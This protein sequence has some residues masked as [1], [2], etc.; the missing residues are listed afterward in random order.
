MNIHSHPS[1]TKSVTTYFESL[2]SATSGGIPTVFVVVCI[3]FLSMVVMARQLGEP[4]YFSVNTIDT[5]TY[6]SWAW[7]FN[8][9]LKEGIIYPR[10]LSLNFWGYGSPTFV[11]YPPLAFYLV[12]LLSSLTDSLLFAMSLAKFTS[13]FF[14]GVAMFYLIREFYPVRIALLAASLCIIFPY[15]VVQ[16]YLMGTFSSS[17]SFMWFPAIMLFT[18]RFIRTGEYRQLLYA[19]VC[20]GG[21][22]LTHLINAYMFSFVIL[23]F[24]VLTSI[25]RKTPRYLI[26]IPLILLTGF[27]IGA[28]YLLPLVFE[29]RYFNLA[30]FIGKGYRYDE[31]FLLPHQ[32]VNV[33]WRVYYGIF[34]SQTLFLFMMLLTIYF[35]VKFA[36]PA[37]EQD[38]LMF[39]RCSQ[40][41]VLTS[42]F[43]LFG[44]STSI[45][46]SIPFIKYVQFP[47]RW[48]N[49]TTF[50]ILALSASGFTALAKSCNSKRKFT[51]ILLGLFAALSVWDYYYIRHAPLYT[52]E[53]LLPAKAVNWAFEHLPTGVAADKIENENPVGREFA[54]IQGGGVAKVLRWGSGERIVR[55]A[56]RKASVVKIRTFNFPGW[57]ARIDGR[58]AAVKTEPGTG[59]ILVDLPAGEHELTLSFEDTLVRKV[60][61]MLTIVSVLLWLLAAVAGQVRQR[62]IRT[63]LQQ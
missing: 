1:R 40:L 34:C 37:L 15:N 24:I 12:A 25:Y 47:V 41:I 7:Q 11:L 48:L 63:G 29:K 51:Y 22:V 57:V 36:R 49:I 32:A 23:A 62:R 61:K 19:G 18:C 59:A 14:Y 53:E 60:G 8:E 46:E 33:F 30:A 38:V 20:Y 3:F 2:G 42:L 45:W 28:A 31:F 4:G 10:W 9:A 55:L 21:L 5:N 54:S 58:T 16:Y 52:R 44:P 50:A 6:A 17:V 13:L 27:A 56:A 26:A 35:V 43:L 39:N